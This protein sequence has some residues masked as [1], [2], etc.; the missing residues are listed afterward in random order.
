M[1]LYFYDCGFKFN[2][3]N[4]Q[5][6]AIE[7]QTRDFGLEMKSDQEFEVIE[8]MDESEY[9]WTMTYLKNEPG[10]QVEH[11]LDLTINPIKV[12]YEGSFVKSIVKFFK[13]ETEL[14]L[15]EQAAE[16]WVDFKE[17]AQTQIQESIKAGR[18]DINI[19]IHSPI[20]L[21][22][23]VQNDPSSKIWAVNLGDF[24][25]ASEKPKD[26][27]EVY[28][29]GI[30]SVMIK[31]Y[32]NYSIWEEAARKM[33]F[34]RRMSK[35]EDNFLEDSKIQTTLN[36]ENFTILEDFQIESVLAVNN[37]SKTPQGRADVEMSAKASPVKFNLNNEIY[38]HLVNIHRCFT[39]ENPEEIVQNMLQEK[40]KVMG[41]AK[42]ISAVKKRGNNIKIW[43]NRYAVISGNY[44][45]F[46]RE[47]NDLVEEESL[48]L[49]D[50]HITDVSDKVEEKH[51]IELNSKFGSVMI[52]F[53]NQMVKDTWKV[54]IHKMVME[55]SAQSDSDDEVVKKEI[56]QEQIQR[57]AN[58]FDLD[59]ICTEV[60]L[61]WMEP[62][63]STWLTANLTNIT[64][65]VKKPVVGFKFIL[66]IGSGL[67]LSHANIKNYSIIA[68]SQRPEKS[69]GNL[70]EVEVELIDK[71][72][73]PSGDEINV[74]IRVGYLM[75]HYYPPIIKSLITRVR[76]IQYDNEYDLEVIKKDYEDRILALENQIIKN[77]KS[78]DEAVR[79]QVAKK[80]E[81][82]EFTSHNCEK[83]PYP[84]IVVKV[85]LSEVEADFLHPIFASPFIK[86]KVGET[87]IDYD[88]F[89]DHD[90]FSGTL[91]GIHVYD[92]INYPY[93]V[94]PRDYKSFKDVKMFELLGLKDANEK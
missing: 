25:L 5:K 63:G 4:D 67:A 94:D 24:S 8:K 73:N 40:E 71:P 28:S 16:K 62:D 33:T 45:Y 84:Y 81:D 13:N 66:G 76:R 29:F 88:M 58:L 52:S 83:F 86:V 75:L 2:Q 82:A 36:P 9:F 55:L 90:E 65:K 21:I 14:N 68:T 43:A 44:V 41:K 77:S 30:S 32:E 38:N 91:G 35:I 72:E 10:H 3:F 37:S 48:F 74:N 79:N 7:A 92:L 27:Y 18:K 69:E 47:S 12:V 31:F 34:T 87:I 42:L 23:L 59:V 64:A 19:F 22:P 46:Y 39:Y 15:K 51:S 49:K 70:I 78:S 1:K 89:V 85:S 20:L 50:T 56:E 57:N 17:G 53:N 60:G 93:T 11:S 80:N 26:N 61:T 54:E 6:M